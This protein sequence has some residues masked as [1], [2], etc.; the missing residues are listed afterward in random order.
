MMKPEYSRFDSAS[1]AVDKYYNGKDYDL[2]KLFIYNW[3]DKARY[4]SV[5]SAGI[6][7]NSTIVFNNRKKYADK[8][9][10]SIMKT[11]DKIENDSPFVLVI[12]RKNEEI[13]WRDPYNFW[14]D[15]E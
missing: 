14:V 11:I 4:E 10:D 13:K 6:I 3:L 9:L 1:R 12:K 2:S 8:I 15:R 5:V 7:L